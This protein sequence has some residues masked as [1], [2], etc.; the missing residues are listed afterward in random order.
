MYENTKNHPTLKTLMGVIKLPHNATKTI[1]AL[2]GFNHV[3]NYDDK[4]KKGEVIKDIDYYH[5]ILHATYSSGSILVSDRDFVFLESRIETSGKIYILD[6]SIEVKEVSEVKGVA[7]GILHYVGWVVKHI[8]D[9]NCELTY[10]GLVDPKGW[11][12]HAIVKSVSSEEIMIVL[13][14]KNYVAKLKD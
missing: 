14:V 4:F 3:K 13:N 9:T 12:P 1:Q 2:Q 5:Q 11:I 6:Q 7:R 8:D 10:L